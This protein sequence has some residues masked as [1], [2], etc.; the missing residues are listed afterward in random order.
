M[1][2]VELS[3][4]QFEVADDRDGPA[5]FMMSVRK[6]GSSMFFKIARQLAL[7]NSVNYVDVAGPLFSRN[8]KVGEWVRS[9]AINDIIRGG[10]VYA[11][12]R[13]FPSGAA[14]N[15]IF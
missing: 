5:F 11:G 10:N 1:M 12:F 9:P 2:V 15:P 6:C 8:I 14:N 13:N 3:G 7:S 4:I